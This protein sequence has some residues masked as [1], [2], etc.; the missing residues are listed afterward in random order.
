MA[1]IISQM[2]ANKRL[3]QKGTLAQCVSSDK[4]VYTLPP[5]DPCFDALVHNK[6]MRAMEQKRV[7]EGGGTKKEG[8]CKEHHDQVDGGKKRKKRRK[9][10][11]KVNDK[12]VT[13]IL[14]GL[15]IL[16]FGFCLL[17]GLVVYVWLVL[18][19]AG[20]GAVLGAAGRNGSYAYEGVKTMR[21]GSAAY[22]MP[23]EDEIT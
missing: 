18:W 10:K 5:F 2:A 12:V 3:R 17:L 20:A 6:Y 16:A 7:A 14:S 21:N 22:I 19:E 1:A 15:A 9:R 11:K 4:C 23:V 8:E 13:E